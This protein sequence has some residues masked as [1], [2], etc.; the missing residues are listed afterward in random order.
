SLV[1]N[2]SPRDIITSVDISERVFV[3]TII[4]IYRAIDGT[5]RLLLL[6]SPG[7]NSLNGAVKAGMALTRLCKLYGNCREL[8]SKMSN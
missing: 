7:T 2:C 6:E 1:T 5:S 4:A 8:V 3:E